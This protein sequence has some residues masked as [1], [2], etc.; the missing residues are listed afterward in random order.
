MAS[1]AATADWVLSP[2]ERDAVDAIA[3][4]DGTNEEVERFGMGADAP[5]APAR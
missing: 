4:W 2:E 5:S 3:G 1:N